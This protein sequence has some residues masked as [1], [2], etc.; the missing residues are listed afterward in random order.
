MLGCDCRKLRESVHPPRFF[1]VQV[2]FR[3]E[4]FDFRGEMGV[5]AFRIE[6]G[7]V[8]DSR[9]AINDAVP[10]CCHVQTKGT[11]Y[12]HPRD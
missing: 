12:S 7:D 6:G 5:I 2:V 3:V 8:V 11:D 10:G 4:P 1:A 9:T